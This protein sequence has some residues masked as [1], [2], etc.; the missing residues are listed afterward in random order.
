[1]EAMWLE[2]EIY[3]GQH[4]ISTETWG[5]GVLKVKNGST[6]ATMPAMWRKCRKHWSNKGHFKLC[7]L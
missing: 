3:S 6:Q 7:T 1:M 5:T 2:W 4:P